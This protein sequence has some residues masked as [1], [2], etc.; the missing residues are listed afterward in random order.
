MIVDYSFNIGLISNKRT[1]RSRLSTVKFPRTGDDLGDWFIATLL[2]ITRFDI[3]SSLKLIKS[4]L[5]GH[6]SIWQSKTSFFQHIQE[7]LMPLVHTLLKDRKFELVLQEVRHSNVP[8]F[9]LLTHFSYRNYFGLLSFHQLI[10]YFVLQ[11]TV[12]PSFQVYLI[13]ENQILIA[14]NLGDLFCLGARTYC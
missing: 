14:F 11:V 2:L 12:G 8:I 13:E 6:N 4:V 10:E 3:E 5:H 9:H 1:I 7:R